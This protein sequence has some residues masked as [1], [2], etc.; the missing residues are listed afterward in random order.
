MDVARSIE[1]LRRQHD[2][3]V[4]GAD[5]QLRA[6]GL[7]RTTAERRVVLAHRKDWLVRKLEETLETR[8][9]HVVAGTGNGADAVGV[10]V[11]VLL[12]EDTPAMLAGLEV[13]REVRRFFPAT[14]VVAQAA[15][16]DRVGQLL[17][18]GARTVFTRQIPP[19]DVARSMPQP[20]HRPVDSPGGGGDT[21]QRHNC[22]TRRAS[23]ADSSATTADRRPRRRREAADGGV[24]VVLADCR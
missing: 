14:V 21:A 11:A 1:V 19:Q 22:C 24:E 9:V 12:V 4:A 18:V 5:E 3:V 2:A 17:D 10:V 13:I 8:G 6:S 7:L 16:G 15:S 20:R 23:R